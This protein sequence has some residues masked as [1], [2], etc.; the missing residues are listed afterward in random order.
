MQESRPK[1][2]RRAEMIH[3]DLKDCAFN[4]GGECQEIDGL[5]LKG[6]ENGTLFCDN[7]Q[8]AAEADREWAKFEKR[9]KAKEGRKRKSK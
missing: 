7:Y 3:C 2:K 4:E 5:S 1:P 9:Q 8:N 6:T